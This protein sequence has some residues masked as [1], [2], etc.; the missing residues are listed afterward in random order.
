[1]KQVNQEQ[2]QRLYQ[3]TRE[4]FVE[5]YDLQSE[6]VDHLANDIENQWQ[7]KP[8]LEFEQALK[9]AFGRF[10]VFG[11]DDVMQKRHAALQKMYWNE[12]WKFTKEYYRIP[13]IILTITSVF[14]LYKIMMAIN[15]VYFIVPFILAEIVFLYKAYRKVAR[16][17]I[18]GHPDKQFII[19]QN[20]K[21]FYSTT[22][23]LVV[24]TQFNVL[25]QL[26]IN[27]NIPLQIIFIA[28]SIITVLFFISL[29]ALYFELPAF[30]ERRI[31][32]HFPQL[33]SA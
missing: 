18:Q 26:A 1:M 11:F 30:M 2:I 17:K 4:H 21:A 25:L 20:L 33:K 7:K 10:G 28:F 27:F 16:Y 12:L 8:E 13:K 3:F 32:E 29:H 23:M 9:N 5:F 14:F 22:G 24:T 31:N 19:Q 6:L 15:S